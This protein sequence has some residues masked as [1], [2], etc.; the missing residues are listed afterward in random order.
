MV[1][2]KINTLD[3]LQVVILPSSICV[4][5]CLGAVCIGFALSSNARCTVKLLLLDGIGFPDLRENMRLLGAYSIEICVFQKMHWSCAFGWR[6]VSYHS[7]I[8]YT[9]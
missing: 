9:F 8:C 7:A 1:F 2:A 4:M 6:A 3:N 5:C